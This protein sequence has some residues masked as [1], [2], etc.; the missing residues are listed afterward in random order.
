V[1]S[2]GV[3][4]LHFAAEHGNR[5]IVEKLIAA[6]ADVDAKDRYGWAVPLSIGGWATDSR[7]LPCR[8]TP[9]HFAA[10]YGHFEAISVL[11]LTRDAAE[12]VQDCNG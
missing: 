3:T 10:E 1:H 8:W 7:R 2:G 9:L 11:L 5:R 12:V 6:N 4:A